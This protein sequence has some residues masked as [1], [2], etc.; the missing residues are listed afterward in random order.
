MVMPHPDFNPDPQVLER[1]ARLGTLNQVDRRLQYQSPQYA[2][3]EALLETVNAQGNHI[4]GVRADVGRV[5]NQ[6][7][8][9]KLRNSIVVAVVTAVLMRAPE[10]FT[11]FYR[12]SQ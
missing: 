6:V 9:L 2:R 8:N 4:R 5:Q 1:A 7:Y 12:L 3:P 10:I 11:F